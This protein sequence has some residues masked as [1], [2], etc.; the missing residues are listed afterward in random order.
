ME[1]VKL[2]KL[3]F[4]N[5]Y[6]SHSVYSFNY[7]VYIC[8]CLLLF[9]T[10]ANG[11]SPTI[12]LP[13]SGLFRNTSYLSK[14]LVLNINDFGAQGDGFTDDTKTLEDIWTLACS[15]LSHSKIVIPAGKSYLVRPINFAGPCHSKVTLRISGTI[16]SPRDPEVWKGLNIHRWFYFHGVKNLIIEGGG[17]LDGRGEEWWARSCKINKTNP[18]TH[19]PTAITFHRCKNLKVRNLTT[20]NSQQMH[21]AFTTCRRVAVSHL[22][23]L[24][25][26]DS[27]NT[28]GI[29]IS[30]SK[31]VKLTNIIVSTGDDCISIVSNSSRI[32]MKNI[33]C[34][35][36]HGISIGSLGKANSSAYVQNVSLDGAYLFNTENGLRIKTW[37]VIFPYKTHLSFY[38]S[39]IFKL[40]TSTV[41]ILDLFG[42]P[43]FLF[44]REAVVLQE[45]SNSR[46]FG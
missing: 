19:A 38:G 42:V 18:C 32:H 36:G 46:M 4:S 21:M 13:T 26:A 10:N 6:S 35:P 40:I 3:S 17:V 39:N 20:I 27:P 14:T 44:N 23:V 8:I 31:R 5:A 41:S 11:F 9:V 16:V 1:M 2:R 30:A 12:Q 43:I 25:P 7:I 28:D 45:K 33:V 15:S 34:G 37:Q 22:N 24:A 29:H